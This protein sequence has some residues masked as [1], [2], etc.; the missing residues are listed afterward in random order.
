MLSPLVRFR[1]LIKGYPSSKIIIYV[2]RHL[3]YHVPVN[4]P[5]CEM[6][7]RDS[8]AFIASVAKDVKII[9][10]GIQKVAEEVAALQTF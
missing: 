9:P 1:H 8:A 10:A 7:P 4:H 2:T 5:S 3:A 6:N